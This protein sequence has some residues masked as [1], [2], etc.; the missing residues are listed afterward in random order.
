ME[1][2]KNNTLHEDFILLGYTLYYL[3]RTGVSM[4]ETQGPSETLASVYRNQKAL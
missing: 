1:Q 4:L 2:F 3:F